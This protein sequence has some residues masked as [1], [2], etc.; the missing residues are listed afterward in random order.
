MFRHLL[1]LTAVILINIGT[2]YSQ[3]DLIF[4]IIDSNNGLSDNRVRDIVQL[5]DG[6]LIICTVGITNIYD[7]T[8]FKQLHEN[9]VNVDSLSRYN[10]YNQAYTDR[11]YLWIKTKHQIRLIDLNSETFVPHPA[12]VLRKLGNGEPIVD[13]FLDIHHDYWMVTSSDKLIYKPA[14]TSGFKV[15][16]EHL[17]Y[18]V[19]RKEKLCNV[20][21]IGKEVF[22]FYSSG[23]MLCYDLRTRKLN[24]QTNILDINETALY[25]NSLKIAQTGDTLYTLYSAKTGILKKFIAH[26]R[27]WSTVLKTDNGLRNIS[28][29]NCKNVWLLS[30]TGLWKVE[31]NT[32]NIHLYENY[33]LIDETKVSTDAFAL[34]CDNQGGLWIGT[35]NRGLLYYHPDRFKFRFFGKSCFEPQKRDIEVNCFLDVGLNKSLVGTSNGLYILNRQTNTLSLFKGL[36][37]DITCLELV[38]DKKGN[39]WLP[40]AN[41]GLFKIVKDKA[42]FATPQ[43]KPIRRV[44]A[45][46]DKLLMSTSDN[47]V[48]LLDENNH[49]FEPV[50]FNSCNRLPE[51]VSQ[52]IP[53]NNSSLLG[54]SSSKVFLINYKQRIISYPVGK[55][56]QNNIKPYTCCAKDSRGLVWIGTMDGIYVWAENADKI[57]ALYTDNGLINNNIKGIVE[58]GYGIVWVTTAGGISRITVN[59]TATDLK[60]T[61]SNFNHFDGVINNEFIAQSVYKASSNQ[62]F[63]GGIG[64]FNMLGLQKA[65]ISRKLPKPLFTNLALFGT[66]I[67]TGEKYNNR[68]VL[69]RAISVIDTVKLNYNQN[70]ISISFSALNYVNPSQTYYRYRLVGN[71]NQWNE[72]LTS[73][74]TGHVSFTNLKPGTYRLQVKAANNSKEWG[75]DY[76][77]LTIIIRPPFWKTTVAYFVYLILLSVLLYIVVSNY[78]QRSLRKLARINEEKLNQMKF[79]FFTNISHEFRTPL[80]LII[81]PLESILKETRGTILEN[82]IQVVWKHAKDLL[83]LV[84]QLLDYRRLEVVGEKLNLSLG[85]ITEFVGQFKI[86]FEK[87]AEEKKINFTV[88][89]PE[90]EIWMYFD[91]SKL[92]R[93]VNNLLSNAFKF[94]PESGT[95]IFSLLHE[96]NVVKF[97]VTDTGIGIPASEIPNIFNNFYQAQGGHQ[98]SGI[99][100]HLVNEY[101]K[102]H[103]GEITIESDLGITTVFTVVLPATLKPQPAKYNTEDVRSSEENNESLNADKSLKKPYKILIVEDNTELRH[104][105]SSELKQLYVIFEAGNGA[106]GVKTAMGEL[107][108]LIISD[109]MMPEMDG[110]ELCKRIKSDITT[111]HIPV[112]LLTAK[113][114]EEHKFEGYKA[115]ADEY[116][117]KPFNLD[118]LRLRINQLIEQRNIRKEQF[119]RKLEVSPADIT[120]SS[121]DKQLIRKALDCIERNMANADYSVYQ[122][123]L[124]MNMD[125]TVLYKKLHSITG[126]T[127]S[128]FIRTL[129]L[130]RAAQLLVQGKYP[131][132]VVSEMVGFNT[133]KYFSKYFKEAFGVLPSQYRNKILD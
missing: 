38:P 110:H 33:H 93:V 102:L 34:Y 57:Y 55:L 32:G 29:D 61:I 50:K 46:D 86:L 83:G 92:Y 36:P 74:G 48:W 84:N 41:K 20:S 120:I 109:V 1:V 10:F 133:Q 101:V 116:I 51:P 127:P 37:P 64:G 17:S 75:N 3:S 60:F 22:L 100:L 118:F 30:R 80:T 85:N 95:I 27:E 90:Q 69:P 98:G 65:W 78:K 96:Q 76:A 87:L 128:E 13:F 43:N 68:I 15:F 11:N 99:G 66:P 70:F 44:I 89:C 62:L 129:R 108:D 49:S 106:D 59:L 21:V 47:E 73:D 18:P 35:L 14:T 124:D 126:L 8:N 107:P 53:F 131:V 31:E 45:L 97:K 113:S 71:N 111:S 115:G 130:K 112:V 19:L 94:T 9:A 104:F 42:E 7:G 28:I 4:S 117:S 2:S 56:L 81:T 103:S 12:N 23:L 82:K 91:Q 125:R 58:D 123:S 52:I 88:K 119:K 77:Q 25:E 39:I 40:S 114:S 5:Q 24:Y 54:I 121:V 26:N 79:E 6:R 132:A 67:K 16:M 105:I 63:F 72:S 122:M